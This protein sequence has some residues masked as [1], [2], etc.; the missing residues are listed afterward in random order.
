MSDTQRETTL[1]IRP[2]STL[3]PWVM[4]PAVMSGFFMLALAVLYAVGSPTSFGGAVE[5]S[6][7]IAVMGSIYFVREFNKANRQPTTVP[8]VG[9][10]RR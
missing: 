5:I 4:V 1:E 8:P 3:Y 7:V 6:T 10:H 2:P 9:R